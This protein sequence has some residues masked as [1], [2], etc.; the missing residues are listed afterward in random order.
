MKAHRPL[1]LLLS[2]ITLLLGCT[3]NPYRSGEA[4][5]DTIFGSFFTEPT[6]LDPTRA[7]YSHEGRIID[8]IYEP[9]FT[10]HYLKR[11]YELIPLTAAEIPTASYYDKHGQKIDEADP[12][13]EKVGRAEYTINIRKG[14]MYQDHPC[15]AVDSDGKSVYGTVTDEDI[16]AYNWPGDFEK[17]GTRELKA[18]DYVLQIKRMADPRLQCDIYSVI[19]EYILGVSELHDAMKE[20]LKKQRQE[21]REEA[22]AGY[23]QELDEKL[24]PIRLDYSSFELSGVELLDDHSYRIVLKRKYPQILYWMCMHFFGPVPQEALDFYD[25][26]P[27]I[28][29]SIVLNRCPVG[30]GPYYLHTYKP[31]EVIIMEA[32]PNYHEDFYPDEGEPGDREAGLLVDAG[33][34]LPFVKRQYKRFEKESLPSFNKF[35]QG[36]Y[37]S[38]GIG[39]DMFDKA[40]QIQ[41]GS[42]PRVSDM[43]AERG[44][45]LITAIDTSFY[46]LS[47]NMLDELVGGYSEEKRKLRQAIS[48]ALDYNEYI[49]IFSNGRGI[50]AQGPIPPGIFGYRSGKAGT[51][52]Y[53][54]EWDPKRNRH[55]RK[56]IAVAKKLLA[57]AGYPGGIGADGQHLTLHYDHS[58]AGDSGFRAVFVWMQGQLARLGIKLDERGTDLS[59]FR[60]KRTEGNWQMS[61]SG[62]LADYPDPENFLFLFYGPN[63]KVKTGGANTVNYENEE[64]DLLFKQTESMKN[65]PARMELIKQLMDILQKDAPA[66]WMVHPVDF[67]LYHTWFTNTKP[68]KMSSN[69]IKFLRVAPERRITAQSAWNKPIIW[70]VVLL[71]LLLCAGAAPAAMQIYRQEKG[72]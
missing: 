61:S 8:Q 31:N 1:I 24:N 43:M 11:P 69:T 60:E 72:R 18:A 10:Y 64:Y 47:F 41:A 42:E 32:N 59:R 55:V 50:M 63:G 2:C 3:N 44:I 40:I 57:E 12:H 34:R 7:Y 6:R 14:I 48:I 49:D 46:Y 51:N 27:M 23:N 19:A 38:S 16:A 54:D 33:K 67:G 39:K 52:P 66:V 58:S 9:P 68:H 56:P 62:W 20:E 28:R 25:Q 37:D 36:Y 21:R 5:E 29:K 22:G 13:Y 4:A 30:T 17:Q 15:F 53:I 35:V 71:V 70:P 26:A 65:S 45:R